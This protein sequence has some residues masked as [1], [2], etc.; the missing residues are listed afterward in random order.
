MNE[1]I[2]FLKITGIDFEEKFGKDQ[3]RNHSHK[4]HEQSGDP[5]IQPMIENFAGAHDQ[6]V[7]GKYRHQHRNSDRKIG[8]PAAAEQKILSIIVFARKI[9]PDSQHR[10]KIHYD[11]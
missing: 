10:N 6:T 5:P 9:P 2:N 1:F 3:Y 8:H 4:R 11:H 7:G